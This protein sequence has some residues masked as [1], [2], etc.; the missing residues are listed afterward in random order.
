MKSTLLADATLIGAGLALLAMFIIIEIEGG[1]LI[2]RNLLIRRGEMLLFTL[3]IGLGLY[4]LIKD[5]RNYLGKG[6]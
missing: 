2:E 5:T 4:R 1:Y 6:V 3:M